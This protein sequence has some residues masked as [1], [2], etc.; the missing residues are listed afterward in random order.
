MIAT[1]AMYDWPQVR[2]EHDRFWQLIRTAMAD[3]GIPAPQDLTRDEKLWELWE[4]P[5]LLLGQTCGMPYR[6]RLH[7]QVELVGT[8]DY[9]LPDAPPG[10][11]YSVFVTR[12]DEP[13]EAVDFIDRTLAFNG[14]DSQSGW[15]A[16][17]NQMAKAGLRFTHTRH[18]GAHRDSARAVAAG[19]ADIAAIDAV[20]W[21]LIDAWHPELSG[22]LRVIGH[23]DPTPGLPLITARGRDTAPLA[24]AV[25]S[26]IT[27]L[28]AED[29]AALGLT[30]LAAI[31]ASAYLAVPTPPP[32][33]QD[34]PVN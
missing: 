22:T 10:H 27:A 30:G 8:P 15:A 25:A 3:E 26:A 13:G 18:T 33:S 14:Q 29:R 9:A 4:S 1:L 12:A 21:R 31:P 16:P 23:T 2:A 20:S 24:R 28:A 7:G 6:T 11:Y 32:P 17:Q 5:D 34:V 19:K